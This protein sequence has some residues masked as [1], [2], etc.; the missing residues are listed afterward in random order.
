MK[1]KEVP[2]DNEGL[3]ED[4]FRDLCYAVD[5][6]GNYIAV[7]SSGWSPKNA[8]MMQAWDEINLKVEK[9][10][11]EV[12]NGEKSILAFHMEKNIM[13]IKLLSQYT[14][15]SRRKIRKHLKPANFTLLKAVDLQKYAEAFNITIAELTDLKQLEAK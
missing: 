10:K 9:V 8:A 15:I 7:H 13:A 11:K 5:D 14:G 3:H 1:E 2:Q 6:D 12:L 4:K